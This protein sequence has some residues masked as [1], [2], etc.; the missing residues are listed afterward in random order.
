MHPINNKTSAG[1]VVTENFL[2]TK[3]QNGKFDQFISYIINLWN[4]K[5]IVAVLYLSGVIGKVSIKKGLTLE[6]LDQQIKDLFS[7]KKLKAICLII[8]SPGGSPVQSELIALRIRSLATKHN[9]PIY[10]FVEDVSASGGYWLACIG[11]E[12]YASK[13]SIIGSIGV[14]S[15]GFGFHKAIEK[16]GIERRIYAQGKNKSILDPFEPAE[17]NDINIVKHIQKEIHEHFISYIK[18]RRA[19]KLTQSDDI[20]FNGEFWTGIRALDFG[21]IDGIGDMYNIIN[22]KFGEVEFKYIKPKQSWFQKKLSI[23]SCE[24]TSNM[25]DALISS[26]EAKSINNKYDLK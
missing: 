18:E 26:I 12:I 21:L 20:L 3:S 17:K 11:D 9:I 2:V 24:I 4:P 22:Q 6:L 7:I 8:N 5:P 23:S 14:I 13:S 15:S 10:S 1:S 25:V 19:G 16:L